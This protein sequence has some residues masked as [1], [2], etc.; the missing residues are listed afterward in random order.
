MKSIPFAF[1]LIFCVAIWE[2]GSSNPVAMSCD[3][4]GSECA[5]ACGT[6]HFRSCCFNYV[7]KRSLS[8]HPYSLNKLRYNILFHLYPNSGEMMDKKHSTVEQEHESRKDDASSSLNQ[9]EKNR[10]L[11]KNFFKPWKENS[12]GDYSFISTD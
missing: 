8:F 3:S 12:L 10:N 4:C 5:R 7:R 11:N 6:R 9:I 2:L 1:L